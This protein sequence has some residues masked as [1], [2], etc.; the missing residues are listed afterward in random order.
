MSRDNHV[1]HRKGTG[2]NGRSVYKNE[3]A[4]GRGSCPETGEARVA[5]FGMGCG[6]IRLRS[7]SPQRRGAFDLID[8]DKVGVTNLN[9]QI[10]ADWDSVGQEKTEVMR[11][12]ML[13][14]NPKADVRVHQTFF[15]P[16]N[17]DQFPLQSTIMWW[18]RWTRSRQKSS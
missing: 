11:R 3:M 17:V 16:E 4:V 14:I 5:V 10:I 8:N 6:W 18:T 9:R 15:L 13:S 1:R 12:R 2:E 7:A